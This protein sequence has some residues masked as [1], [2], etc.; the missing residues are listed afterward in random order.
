MRVVA[1]TNR[2]LVDA[3]DEGSFR[4]DLY[5]RLSVFPLELPPL[6][7]RPGDVELL[8]EHF[9]KTKSARF[10]KRISGL[11]PAAR[12]ALRAYRWP[13]NV[14]ELENVI[15]RAVILSNGPLLT[16]DEP[17]GRRTESSERTDG[18]L[19]DVERAHILR[20]LESTGWVIEGSDAAAS[21]LGLNPST[22]RSRMVKLR[23][24][25]PG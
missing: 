7:E 22:L 12:T 3:I 13:G 15:E 17:F 24:K 16:L 25:K 19:E 18:T 11:A 5:Y 21:R 23:I 2:N 20:V 8:A 14:R 4:E 10:G 1:A 6:R 9:V